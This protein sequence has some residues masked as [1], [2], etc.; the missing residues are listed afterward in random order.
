MSKKVKTS[1]I[2]GG[3]AAA[4]TVGT[5]VST[6]TAVVGGS[7]A[8]I[9]SATSGTIGAS[10]AALAGASG[11]VGAAAISSGMATIG[12]F[13]GGGM[14]AGAVIATATPIV[15]IGAAAYGLVKYFEG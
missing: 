1:S 7:A 2:V 13:V 11:T 9:M 12:S 10:T 6:A 3:T 8:T 15:V 4:V 14:A 5:T